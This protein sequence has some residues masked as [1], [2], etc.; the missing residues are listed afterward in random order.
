MRHKINQN[1]NFDI[2]PHLANAAYNNTEPSSANP[3]F[4]E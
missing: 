2:A 3:D 4:D 1:S